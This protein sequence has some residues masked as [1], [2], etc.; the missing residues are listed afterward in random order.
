M[1]L[2]QS[3]LFE[4]DGSVA[5]ITLN[6]PDQ[7]NAVDADMGKQL[8][9]AFDRFEADQNLRVA[10]LVANG[11]VFCAGMDL[12]AFVS[13]EAEDILFGEGH[14]GGFVSRNRSKPVIAAVQGHA[15]A[16]GFELVLACDLVIASHVSKFGLPECKRGLVAG[17]GG[18]FR[19]GLQVPRVIANEILLTGAPISADR[20]AELGIINRVT[21]GDVKCEALMLA[22]DVAS[23]APLSIAAS[24]HL[25]RLSSQLIAD[26]CWAE[27]DKY[28]RH[29]IS[30]NDAKEGA[31]AFAEKREPRWTG[32]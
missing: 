26:A 4:C 16:G 3:V 21:D 14:L 32:S 9:A 13:G 1:T 17:A 15:L 20:A 6:R 30:S 27:N 22:K 18:A 25:A 2:N 12:K 31:R 8:S 28:L 29:L 5:I 23:N 24:L 10:V 19:I 7:R 11:P